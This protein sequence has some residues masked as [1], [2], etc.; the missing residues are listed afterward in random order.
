MAWDGAHE[1]IHPWLVETED[2]S[3]V[4]DWFGIGRTFFVL[5]IAHSRHIVCFRIVQELDAITNDVSAASVPV[6]E[7]VLIIRVAPIDCILGCCNSLQLQQNSQQQH[8]QRHCH[9]L[10]NPTITIKP[11]ANSSC[12]ASLWLAYLY[13]NRIQHPPS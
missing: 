2:S 12:H 13:E 11:H 9:S 1:E 8:E 4:S 7:V 6:G 5:L 3:T 10:Q